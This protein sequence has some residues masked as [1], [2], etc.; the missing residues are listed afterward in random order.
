MNYNNEKIYIISTTADESVYIGSTYNELKF[1]MQ[2]HVTS[3]DFGKMTPLYIAM[4]KHGIDTFSIKLLHKFP[5]KDRTEL[6]TEERRVIKKY[7]KKGVSL[8]N[9]RKTMTKASL[10]SLKGPDDEA[11]KIIAQLE[12]D[13][14]ALDIVVK[15]TMFKGYLSRYKKCES[16]L[17]DICIDVGMSAEFHGNQCAECRAELQRQ[18]YIARKSSRQG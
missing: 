7:Q 18:R 17:S 11:L 5:C 1:R 6:E 16:Q 12:Q 4:R 10:D 8:Y 15:W 2:G 3:A 9:M 13:P 14:V